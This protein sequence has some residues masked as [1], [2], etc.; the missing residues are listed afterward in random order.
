M[1]SIQSAAQL[2]FDLA[3]LLS[4]L[5]VLCFATI[6]RL[7]GVQLTVGLRRSPKGLSPFWLDLGSAAVNKQFDTRDET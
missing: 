2:V 6:A 4:S 3:S 7:Y 1:F 5:G